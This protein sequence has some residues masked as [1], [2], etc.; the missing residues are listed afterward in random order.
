MKIAVLVF[1]SPTQ[2]AREQQAVCYPPHHHPREGLHLEIISE[3]KELN[4]L[5]DLGTSGEVLA[6]GH[7]CCNSSLMAV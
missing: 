6:E 4:N 3:A 1:F 2:V 5:A 7:C